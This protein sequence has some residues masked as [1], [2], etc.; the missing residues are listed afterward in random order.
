MSCEQP[1]VPSEIAEFSLLEPVSP[2]DSGVGREVEQLEQ[3]WNIEPKVMVEQKI[4]PARWETCWEEGECEVWG[5]ST[6]VYLHEA[7]KNLTR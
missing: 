5:N 1:L 2:G 4:P 7:A 6:I 3:G